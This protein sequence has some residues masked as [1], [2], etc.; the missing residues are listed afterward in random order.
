MKK[1]ERQKGRRK[2]MKYEKR[3]SE[4]ISYPADR[5]GR[6]LGSEK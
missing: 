1:A 6:F 2:K 5:S 3:K 4:C